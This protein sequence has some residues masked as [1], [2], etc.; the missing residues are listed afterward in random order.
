MRGVRADVRA[1]LEAR[2]ESRDVG[3]ELGRIAL[4]AFCEER[5]AELRRPELARDALDKAPERG[6]RI[7]VIEGEDA[8]GR[9]GHEGRSRG[10]GFCG[11][12]APPAPTVYAVE[13][14]DALRLRDGAGKEVWPSERI[15][16]PRSRT[17]LPRES[18]SGE[19]S[20]QTRLTRCALAVGVPR[21]R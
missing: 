21:R 4:C 16:E 12:E 13:V 17:P 18:A 6:G 1:R 9:K 7:G 10:D 3:S 20:R 11:Q 15:K 2:R 5:Q 14:R 8:L 19:A